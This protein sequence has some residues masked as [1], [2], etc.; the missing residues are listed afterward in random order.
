MSSLSMEAGNDLVAISKQQMLLSFDQEPFML[1]AFMLE[2]Y[3]P[4]IMVSSH[5][6][7]VLQLAAVKHGLVPPIRS[8]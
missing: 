3:T 1:T 5:A 4:I 6:L 2:Y 7:Q 8:M